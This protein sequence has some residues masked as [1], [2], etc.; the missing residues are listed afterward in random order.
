VGMGDIVSEDRG[1]LI[2]L[3]ITLVIIIIC[4]GLYV[5]VSEFLEK[6]QRELIKAQREYIRSLEHQIN[7]MREGNK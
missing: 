7:R 3:I 5:L 4:A 1:M 2:A 6:E